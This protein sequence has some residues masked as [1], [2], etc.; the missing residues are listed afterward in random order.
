MVQFISFKNE[1]RTDKFDAKLREG[2]WLGLDSRTDEHIMGAG[3]GIYRTATLKG[4]PEDKRWCAAKV[5]EVVGMPWEPT[6]NVD[7]EDVVRVPN[8]D[9]A[10]AEVLPEDLEVPESIARRMYIRKT[11]IIKYG[12]TDGCIG[13]RTTMLGKPLKS[14]TPACRE[15]IEAWLRET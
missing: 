10:E 11:D 14:H 4:V 5:L 9:A 1:S 7:A 8:P 3:Y 12:E 6:P 2:I 15:R 13:Y